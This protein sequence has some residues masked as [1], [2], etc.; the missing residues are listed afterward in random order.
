MKTITFVS[1]LAITL[2]IYS[3]GAFVPPTQGV[4]N[5]ETVYGLVV[6][7]DTELAQQVGGEWEGMRK[8]VKKAGKLTD[9]GDGNCM[10]KDDCLLNGKI[11]D[12]AKYKCED[13]PSGFWARFIG[14]YER[15]RVA[16]K[17]SSW[18]SWNY[19]TE[20]CE[21]KTKKKGPAHY[22]CDNFIEWCE[23]W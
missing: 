2:F 6:L 11:S 9:C 21:R 5:I 20:T 4:A 18:C 23:K 8:L 17:V 22:S 14:K 15:V 13:C 3:L 12:R 10:S 1:I 16:S 7:S 19:D